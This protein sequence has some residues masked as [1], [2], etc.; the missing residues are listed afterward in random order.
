MTKAMISARVDE[1]LN[2]ELE[3]LAASS[4]RS[5]AF[6]ITE[7]LENYVEREAWINK[8]IDQDFR[9]ADE[10]GKWISHEAME[11]WI[12]SLGTANELPK[13]EPDVFK[14]KVTS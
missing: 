6:L 1:K 8:K 11:K 12:M 10:S 2:E 3:K 4:R 7:A 5:K 9:A 13:P 14:E